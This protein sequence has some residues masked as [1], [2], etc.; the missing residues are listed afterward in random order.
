MICLEQYTSGFG[1][2][3][4]SSVLIIIQRRIY[5]LYISCKFEILALGRTIYVFVLS[6]SN[7]FTHSV[8]GIGDFTPPVLVA[9]KMASWMQCNASNDPHFWTFLFMFCMKLNTKRLIREQSVMWFVRNS[10]KV[11]RDIRPSIWITLDI[12]YCV[13]LTRNFIRVVTGIRSSS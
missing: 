4:W 3:T 11:L 8:V 12:T 9:H 13:E 7:Y 6:M 2:Y 5:L 10:I 1:R